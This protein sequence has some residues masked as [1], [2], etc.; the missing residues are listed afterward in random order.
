MY[1]V[2][3][4]A[5]E[6]LLTVIRVNCWTLKG[7]PVHFGHPIRTLK[8]SAMLRGTWKCQGKRIGNNFHSDG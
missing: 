3:E 2:V 4:Y 5:D 7:S 1:L 6:T 8:G